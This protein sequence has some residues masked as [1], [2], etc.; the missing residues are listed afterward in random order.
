MKHLESV[1]RHSPKGG[2][3]IGWSS[4]SQFAECEWSWFLSNVVPHPKGGFGVSQG[5]ARPLW[6]GAMFHSAMQ[7]WFLSAPETAQYSL[8]AA[9]AG[10]E[11]AIRADGL[12]ERDGDKAAEW[13]SEV[14]QLFRRYALECGPQGPD[15]DGDRFRVAFDAEG[16]LVERDFEIDLGYQGYYYTS[17]IDLVAWDAVTK[18]QLLVVEHKTCDV[19]RAGSALRGYALDPQLSGETLA[20]AAAWQRPVVPVINMVKKRAAAKSTCRAWEPMPRSQHDLE[21]FRIDVVRRLKRMDERV[22]E[23]KSLVDKGVP[24]LDAGSLV[25]DGSPKGKICAD[26]GRQ[27]AFYS[28]CYQRSTREHWLAATEPRFQLEEGTLA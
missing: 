8:D 10:L 16:P 9:L 3:R 19:S 25:F 1:L 7:A 20:V 22:E 17:R 6:V 27:C 13:E 23:Y 12:R 2:S 18:G 15:P 11:E 14:S 26:Q 24:A 5:D 28:A 4:I 21:K